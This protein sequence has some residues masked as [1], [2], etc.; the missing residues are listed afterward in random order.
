MT[1]A[2]YAGRVPFYEFKCT[3]CG[4]RTLTQNREG[5]PAVACMSCV[6][7]S[8]KRVWSVQFAPVMHAHLNKTTGS[9]VSSR[10]QFRDELARKSDEMTE[11]TGMP[12]NYVEVDSKDTASLKVT[13]EG[14]DTTY[15]R[16]RAQG[17]ALA[18]VSK[19]APT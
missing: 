12:H 19:W 2:V 17:Q 18:P 5:G 7:A 14:L 8:W 10:R 15:D 16:K 3:G 13:D 1:A 11:R 4:A 6:N 9:V